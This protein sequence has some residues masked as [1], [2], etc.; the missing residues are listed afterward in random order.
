MVPTRRLDFASV[1]DLCF[2]A[3]RGR[4]DTARATVTF[5]PDE[6]GPA[7]ELRQYLENSPLPAIDANPWVSSGSL[8]A[9]ISAIN[10][11][12]QEWINPNGG[13][14]NGFI[15]TTWDH[16]TDEETWMRFSL[17]MRRAATASGIPAAQSRQLDAAIVELWNNIFDHSDAA[18][19]GV[20]AYQACQGH[21][22]FVVADNGAGVL[23]SLRRAK[24][25]AGLRGH[26]E[27]LRTALTEG[28]SRFG[29]D[30]GRG[31]GFRQ[32]FLSLRE[33]DVSLRFRSGDHALILEGDN[34]TLTNAKLHEKAMLGGFFVSAICRAGD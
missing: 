12:R 32:M 3:E 9:M 11:G 23:Q 5:F 14:V 30:R 25:F 4:L 18:N 33:L 31:F 7:L 15:R 28:A 13:G 1:D 6:I 16:E 10:L 2:A 20:V 21:F 26:G 22:A 19:T 27:A 34:P 24:E 17:S 29:V 8:S